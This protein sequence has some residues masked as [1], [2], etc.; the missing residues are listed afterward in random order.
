MSLETLTPTIPTLIALAWSEENIKTLFGNCTTDYNGVMKFYTYGSTGG[1]SGEAASYVVWET[2]D[3]AKSANYI[4]Q[5]P[6]M[7]VTVIVM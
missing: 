6:L 3:P 2:R 5:G 1:G 4:N 7:Y